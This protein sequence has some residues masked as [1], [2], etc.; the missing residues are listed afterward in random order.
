MIRTDVA[1]YTVSSNETVTVRVANP[2]P[3]GIVAVRET[4]EQVPLPHSIT[5]P[6]TG[7]FTATLDVTFSGGIGDSV[8]VNR[9]GFPGGS[10]K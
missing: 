4:G 6:S 2:V 10:N 8:I 5:F 7:P 9:P 3:G 1:K